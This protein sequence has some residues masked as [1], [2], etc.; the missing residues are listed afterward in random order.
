MI[1]KARSPYRVPEGDGPESLEREWRVRDAA[2]QASEIWE[3]SGGAGW[4]G[5]TLLW[6]P[7]EHVFWLLHSGLEPAWYASPFTRDFTFACIGEAGWGR[8]FPPLRGYVPRSTCCAIC[9]GALTDAD[10][11]LTALSAIE[12]GVWMPECGACLRAQCEESNA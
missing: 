11:D 8:Y 7:D 2:G 6:V 12:G 9:D 1:N 3:L 10:R 5:F 4:D